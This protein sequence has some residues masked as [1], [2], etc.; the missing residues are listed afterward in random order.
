MEVLPKYFTALLEAVT[1]ES[2]KMISLKYL[3]GTCSRRSAF[4]ICLIIDIASPLYGSGRIETDIFY[5]YLLVLSSDI[6][7]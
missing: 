3:G 7:S 6:G 1:F 4:I 2:C 5:C